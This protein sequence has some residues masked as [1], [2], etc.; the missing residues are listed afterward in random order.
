MSLSCTAEIEA[1]LSAQSFE[2]ARR[3]CLKELAKNGPNSR[4][5]ILLHSAYLGLSDVAARRELLEQIVPSNEEEAFEILLLKAQNADRLSRD[6]GGFY[7]ISPEAKA[8]LTNDEYNTK[9]QGIATAL[10]QELDSKA[11]TAARHESISA[12]RKALERFV[13]KAEPRTT[14]PPAAGALTGRLTFADGAPVRDAALTL[15]LEMEVRNID[16]FTFSGSGLGID[17]LLLAPQESLETR[18][19][20]DGCFCFADVPAGR[21]EFLAVA[22]DPDQ[23]DIA[24]RFIAQGIEV[25]SGTE[26]KLDL[27]VEEWSSV[28]SY[29]VTSPFQAQLARAGVSYRLVHEEKLHNPF[30]YAFPRQDVRFALPIGVAANPEK[31]LLLS[32]ASDLPQPFQII[33][34]ELVYF[35]ELPELTDRVFALYVAE[36]GRAEAFAETGDLLPVVEADGTAVIDTGVASFRIPFGDGANG[37]PPLIS[38]RGVD[39]KWR[40]QGGFRLPAGVGI[41][42][43]STVVGIR[44]PLVLEWTTRYE[45]SNGSRY[46]FR[47]TAHRGE[48]YLLAHELSA[49]LEGAAFEFSLSEFVGGR[50]YLQWCSGNLHWTTLQPAPCE[51]ARLQESV[52]WWV[53]PAGFGY[54]MTQDGLEEKDFIAVF[55][56]RRGEWVDRDFERICEGPIDIDGKE[57]RELDWPFPEMV[58]STISMITANT[59]AENGG[60]AFF[61][62]GFFNGERRWGLLVSTVEQN[63]PQYKEIARVQHKNSSPRLQ[64]FKDWHL[65]EQDHVSRPCVVVRRENLQALRKKK[66]APAFRKLW[67]SMAQDKRGR[68]VDSF[69][70]AIDG[71]DPVGVWRKKKELVINAPLRARM[72]L[73]GRDMGDLYSPVGG[74]WISLFVENYDLIAASG[75]FTPEEERSVR[76]YFILM[77]HMFMEPDFM[78]WRNNSRNANFES[79]RTE[80]IGSIG[81]AFHGHPSSKKFVTHC[82]ELMERSLNTYCTP[83]SGK[84]Y[85][86]PACYYLAALGPRVN[87]AFHL[88]EHGLFDPTCMARLKDCLSWGILLLTPNFPH[89]YELMWDGCSHEQYLGAGKV[90]R[91]PPIGDH[92]RLGP[93]IPEQFAM[94]AKLY[95]AKDPAFADLLLWAYQAGGSDGGYFSNKPAIFSSLEE[96]DLQLAPQGQ[97]V[98]RRLEGFGA[99]F[100]GG[101]NTKREFYLL[102]KQGPGGYR[103]HRTEGS[104]VMFAD[105]K[106]LIYDGGE[107]GET[108]RHTTLSFH[109]VHMPLACGHV[110]RFHSF[111]GVDFCQGVHPEVIKPGEPIQL[112][113]DCHHSLVPVAWARYREPNPVNVRSVL[114][115]KDEYVILHDDLRID[116]SIPS[117]WHAQVVADGETGN[118]REGYRFKG[119]FGTDL[120]LLL[121][122]QSFA[123]ESCENLAPLEYPAERKNRFVMR[124]V[125]LTGDQADHYLAVL[126]P[127]SAGKQPVQ[128]REIRQDERTRGVRVEGDGINDL[129]FLTRDPLSF[130]EGGVSFEGRYGTV[131]RRATGTQLALLA[132]SVIEA[133]GLRIESSGPAVFVTAGSASTEIVAD[134]EGLVVVTRDGKRHTLSV[135]GRVTVLLPA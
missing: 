120:Q 66:D 109:D 23:F 60:D 69:L 85:E 102:F 76:A 115:V 97:L 43:R 46:E 51:L 13:P 62:F 101:F 86:N 27:V 32:S 114:W 95:R 63:D 119:R 57:N 99:V 121:P 3:H 39:G 75:A 44:G 70:F 111:E 31:L 1:L 12:A 24:T 92:A 108:W 22:L 133:E 126:R 96:S 117:F 15:G 90:R 25:A 5:Q 84:W 38:V 14:P 72:V 131:V 100:R 48:A 83:G 77:A 53:P 105:G 64:D 106:P 41:L 58:G 28:P 20:S 89:E 35:A 65:D 17:H 54:A 55:T 2:L 107:A 67:N 74:R 124:H 110:E 81:L 61:K 127:L 118:S 134:G 78:N 18:T 8:G 16:P 116:P 129:I 11:N 103:F 94:M 56:I 29:E 42:S 10:W 130:A 125:Q 52:P 79:D 87:L 40:G 135:S 123:A 37:L 7:R 45:L 36:S 26:T 132:G 122:D 71:S 112:N 113:D 30:H 98:S 33:G 68:G 47:F 6:E 19:D 49:D 104:I 88:A 4:I 82:M 59:T 128:A 91:I 80:I 34:S 93:W 21:H 73:L 9:W 50:G